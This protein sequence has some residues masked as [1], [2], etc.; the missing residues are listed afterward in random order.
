M[1]HGTPPATPFPA[2]LLTAL[3]GDPS[4]AAFIHGSRTVTRQELLD[5]IDRLAGAYA[6]YGLGPGSTLVVLVDT[7]PE[8]FAAYVAGYLTGCRLVPLKPGFPDAGR[9]QVPAETDAWL[10]DRHTVGYARGE[11]GGPGPRAALLSLGPCDGAVDLLAAGRGTSGGPAAVRARPQDIARVVYTSGSSGVPKGCA[12]SY[13][14]LTSHWAWQPD[15]WSPAVRQLAA[16]GE[17]HLLTQ[18]LEYAVGGDFMGL[19]LL[20]GGTVVIPE[21]Y[22]LD[23]LLPVIERHRVT[24]LFLGSGALYR[25]LASPLARTTDLGSLRGLT[26]AGYPVHPA[27]LV[28]AAELLG[29]VLHQSYGQC[30]TGSLAL[31]TPADAERHGPGVWHATGRP[32]PSV[33]I[34]IRDQDGRCAATG[35]AGNLYIRSPYQMSHYV[36]APELTA[37]TL[38]EGWLRTGDVARLDADGF[39]HVL[40]REGDT[41]TVDGRDFHPRTVADRFAAH[42]EVRQALVLPAGDAPARVDVYL[43]PAPGNRPDPAALTRRVRAELDLPDLIRSVTLIDEVPWNAHAKPDRDALA[44]QRDLPRR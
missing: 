14:A 23:T 13:A 18:P 35:E 41:V 28:E 11:L 36:D 24:S 31:L 39:L 25:L 6:R 27:R 12:H 17:R 21:D 44:L 10:V 32:H 1:T 42:P 9:R 4:R 3:A 15:T 5:Q 43:V 30:E 26:F 2:A 38:H 33:D 37:R 34:D 22:R 29:P 20:S 8:T 7:R 19:S 16:R 40:G